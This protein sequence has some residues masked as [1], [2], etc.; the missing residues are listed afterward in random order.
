MTRR[1]SASSSTNWSSASAGKL[2]APSAARTASRLS[3][4]KFRS[5]IYLTLITRTGEFEGLGD[6]TGPG[7][8]GLCTLDTADLF[9]SIGVAESIE[10]LGEARLFELSG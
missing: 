4:T 1:R 10:S 3:L 2:R 6:T 8:G 7:L 5:N 9:L